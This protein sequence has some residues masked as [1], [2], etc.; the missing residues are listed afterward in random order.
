MCLAIRTDEISL[1]DL[2]F[3]EFSLNPNE[4]TL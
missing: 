3:E 2:V 1:L 4:G